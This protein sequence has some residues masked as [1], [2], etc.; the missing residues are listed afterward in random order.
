VKRG[1]P[2]HPKVQ[3]LAELL[4]VEIPTAIGYLELLWHFAAEF[5]PRGDIG[6]F[7][8]KRIEAACHF[9]ISRRARAL[10]KQ[11][12]PMSLVEAMQEAGWIEAHPTHRL[13]I[14]DWEDHCD[15]A[16]RKRVSRAGQSFVSHAVEMT[17]QRQTT[18]DFVGLARARLPLPKPLPKPEPGESRA[19]ADPPPAHQSDDFSQPGPDEY[20]QRLVYGDPG[21][22]N[23]LAEQHWTLSD[24]RLCVVAA[25]DVFL[26]ATDPPGVLTATREQHAKYR[27]YH[28]SHPKIRGKP[29][30]YW[31]ADGQY[32][33]APPNGDG[34]RKSRFD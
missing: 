28:A 18:A 10:T 27:E 5:A 7:P 21:E 26:G 8:D 13:T 30:Q 16:V 29:L 3:H 32:L 2:R 19:A 34:G 14:H 17:G 6:R 24:P 15:D 11:T 23:G 4:S 12:R 9:E 31:I 20:A 25:R 22:H 33:V 1:T